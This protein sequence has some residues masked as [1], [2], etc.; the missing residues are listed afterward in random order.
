MLAILRNLAIGIIR[1]ATYRTVNIAAATRQLA[2]ERHARSARHPAATLQMAVV[3][4]VA[5]A[6]DH[7]TRMVTRDV[8]SLQMTVQAAAF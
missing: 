8:P 2:A 6:A 3:I 4:A 5:P 1:H 7:E